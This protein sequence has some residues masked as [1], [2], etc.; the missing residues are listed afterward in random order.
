[1]LVGPEFIFDGTTYRVVHDGHHSYHAAIEDGVDP[2][3]I[4]QDHRD[5][6]NIPRDP[7]DL[8]DDDVL[9]DYLERSYGDDDWYDLETGRTIN[10]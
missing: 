4:E 9:N 8:S 1:M 2:E 7:D 6:D 5:N 10:W 3:F